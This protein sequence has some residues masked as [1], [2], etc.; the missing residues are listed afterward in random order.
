MLRPTRI[1]CTDSANQ[2]IQLWTTRYLP[3]LSAFPTAKGQFPSAELVETASTSGRISTAEK[4]RRMLH[5]HSEMAGVKANSL[6]SYVPN[7]VDLGEAR[8]MAFF[9]EH[10]YEQT[11]EIY[12]Q[13]EPPSLYLKYVNFSSSLFTKL[14]LP[15]LMLPMLRQLAEQIEPALLKL[16]EQHLATANPRTIGF[17]TTH[18]H[19]C[20]RQL[21]KKLTPCEQALLIPYLKFVEEQVCIPWGRICAAAASHRSTSQEFAIVKHLLPMT[22]KIAETVYHQGLEQYA[23]HRSRRGRFNDPEIAV[24][25]LRDLTMFQGYLW[26]CFLEG[27]MAAIEEELLPLCLAVFPCID[28][29]WHL[30]EHLIKLLTDE[31]L[32]ALDSE[33]RRLLLPYTK[34]LQQAFAIADPINGQQTRVSTLASLRPSRRSATVA[35]S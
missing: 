22:Q 32:A 11:L 6:F 24:S 5:L 30:V 18:F 15:S 26:L 19:F 17:L 7:V 34:A 23:G 33:Q 3:D 21:L 9:V 2:L 13:Q 31:I 16:Q 14:A 1:D 29:S 8:Q 4:V 10:V 20:T 27:T 35:S 28:V 12:K 25:T